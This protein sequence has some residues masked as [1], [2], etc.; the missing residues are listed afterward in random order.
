MKLLW[1]VTCIC[2]TFSIWLWNLY[3]RIPTP[4]NVRN[5]PPTKKEQQKNSIPSAV[6]DIKNLNHQKTTQNQPTPHIKVQPPLPN[7]PSKPI[8][9]VSTSRDF[10]FFETTR[11][12]DFGPADPLNLYRFSLPTTFAQCPH[13]QTLLLQ[14]WANDHADPEL[15]WRYEFVWTEERKLR[16][17][18]LSLWM[19]M[20]L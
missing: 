5:I 14:T 20:W 13:C 19:R 6:P 4:K 2:C 3:T 16:I 17:W 12:R 9:G 10:F 11:W 15:L 1:L 7:I 18:I 8:R